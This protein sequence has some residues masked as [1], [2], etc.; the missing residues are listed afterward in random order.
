MN[1]FKEL[2]R[3]LMI[4]LE[5][6]GEVTD[7]QLRE[8]IDEL[9]LE[10]SAGRRRSLPDKVEL[11]KELF[12]SI[13]GLD[14]L[15]ELIEDTDV[16]EIMVNGYDQIFIEKS[17]RIERLSK[18]FTSREKLE[19]VI[20]QIVGNC[21]RI[22]NESRPI[23]DARLDNGARVN[24]V[25]EP[26]CIGGPVLTIRRFP[27]VPIDME[28]LI[29]MESITREAAACL[30]ELVETGYSI[31]IGGGTSTGKTTFLNALSGYIPKDE[32]I[33]TIE[34]TAE[35]QIQGIENLV[36]LEARS[37]NLEEGRSITIRDLIKT[38]LRMRPNR[39]VIITGC[40]TRKT[41]AN[42]QLLPS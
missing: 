30:K 29:E 6:A 37:A 8:I 19:D 41:F 15:Q 16:T 40:H 5:E 14:V 18:S 42:Q 1:D 10:S 33:I 24:V 35:L 7:E 27:D 23:V 22:I 36:R 11:H 21:N 20:Q 4:R 9:L 31:L 34:D 39:V 25:V 2:Q 3:E 17:G 32:R 12:D 26:A 28:Q 38:A 13:R